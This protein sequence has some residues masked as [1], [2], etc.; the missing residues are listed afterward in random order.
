MLRDTRD[1][2][3]GNTAYRSLCGA[4]NAKM[5]KV[6]CREASPIASSVS[7]KDV[8]RDCLRNT[9]PAQKRAPY[10]QGCIPTSFWWTVHVVVM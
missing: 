8:G 2:R 1:T 5:C 4:P 6:H 9:P 10:L 7:F 3:L